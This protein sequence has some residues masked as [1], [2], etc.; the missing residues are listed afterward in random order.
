MAFHKP[1]LVVLTNTKVVDPR[2]DSILEQLGFP[3]F[4]KSDSEVLSGGLAILWHNS[5]QVQLISTTQEIHVKIQV[6]PFSPYF[7]YYFAIYSKT[8]VDDFHCLWKI[9]LSFASNFQGPWL[10]GEF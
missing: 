8:Y 1:Q 4:I 5:I 9:L 6:S 7:F 10:W 3:N 2:V